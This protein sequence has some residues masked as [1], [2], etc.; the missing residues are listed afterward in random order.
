MAKAD[1]ARDQGDYDQALAYL[2]RAQRIDPDNAEI[3]L[4]AK[5]LLMISLQTKPPTYRPNQLARQRPAP[6][7]LLLECGCTWQQT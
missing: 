1:D 7:Q 5:G 3:Y 6:L 2:E 4:S